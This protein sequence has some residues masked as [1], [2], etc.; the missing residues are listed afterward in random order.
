MFRSLSL[1]VVTGLLG[2]GGLAQTPPP[3]PGAQ[4]RPRRP[5]P[6]TRDPHTPGYVAAKELPDGAVPPVNEDGNFIIGPTHNPAPEMTVKEGVPQGEVIEFTMES[7]DSKIYPGIAREPGTFGRPDPAD[8]D[9]GD[10]VTDDRPGLDEQVSDRLDLDEALASIPEDFR[11]AVILRDQLG[12]DYAEIAAVLDIPPGTVR[13]RIA[14]GRA[15]LAACLAGNRT[16][17]PDVGPDAP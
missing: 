12:L 15:G 10:H 5:P 16:A 2:S 6:P 9:A 13:S 14:R 3:A 4:A 17:L 8:P 1:V 7:T 11:A